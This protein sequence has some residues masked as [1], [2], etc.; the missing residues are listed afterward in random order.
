MAIRPVIPA[1]RHA[2]RTAVLGI[3][4]SDSRSWIDGR[5]L[6]LA[7]AVL[8]VRTWHASSVIFIAPPIGLDGARSGPAELG[9][10]RCSRRTDGSAGRSERKRH[11]ES[12]ARPD[13]DTEAAVVARRSR[14]RGGVMGLIT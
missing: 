9:G 7:P 5:P 14:S 11:R 2:L 12:R 13:G 3:F 4:A 10:F 6:H 8:S 1:A